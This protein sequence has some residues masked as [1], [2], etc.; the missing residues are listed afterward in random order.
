MFLFNGYYDRKYGRIIAAA[1]RKDNV[2]YKGKTHSDCLIQR[3]KGEL[4]N[5]EQGFL[6]ENNIFVDRKV[7]LKIAKHYKQILY[8]HPPKNILFSEDLFDKGGNE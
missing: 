8:K 2:I 7:A 4:R 5:A 6:T 1:I 3:P